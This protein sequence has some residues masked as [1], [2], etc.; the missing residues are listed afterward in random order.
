MSAHGGFTYL[1]I[2][3]SKD[4]AFMQQHNAKLL[5]DYIAL[6][7]AG[8][9]INATYG[10]Y[11]KL[12]WKDNQTLDNDFPPTS[13]GV[14]VPNYFARF[15][16]R[17]DPLWIDRSPAMEGQVGRV[18]KPTFNNTNIWLVQFKPEQLAQ[19]KICSYQS[20]KYPWI[21]AVYKYKHTAMQPNRPDVAHVTIP[22]F[23]GSGRYLVH[24]LWS[25]YRDVIDVDYSDSTTPVAEI[26]GYPPTTARWR[27]IDHCLFDNP[28]AVYDLSE[29]VTDATHCLRRC[30][31]RSS[32]WGVNVVP[33]KAPET[34]YKFKQPADTIWLFPD[35]YGTDIY[36]PWNLTVFNATKSR[37]LANATSDKFICYTVMPADF[38][39]TTD[40]YTVS[41]DPDD[42]IFY[43]TCYYRYRGYSFPGYVDNT[44]L[45]PGL[46]PWRFNDKCV[47]CANQAVN[48]YSNIV[49]QWSVSEKCI[50][51]DKE[52]VTV[53]QPTLPTLNLIES[54]VKCDGYGS[55]S[56]AN[57]HNCTGPTNTTDCY[58]QLYPLGRS[59]STN[60][61]LDE[62]RAMVANNPN[63][64]NY[65]SWTFNATSTRCYC[66][67][68]KECCKTCSR[69]IDL[70]MATYELVTV[71]DPNCDT[72][73]LSADGK[74]CC[75]ASCGVGGC[76]NTTSTSVNNVGFCHA[77][78]IT[79]SCTQYGP[80]CLIVQ[81]KK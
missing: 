51:C 19:D 52:P 61:T 39:D 54:G 55:W 6:A 70:A 7:P 68:T 29:V 21:E 22:G 2:V 80:P 40:E 72:G 14:S 27:R 9:T 18:Q 16:D 59:T 78:V 79:R 67:L 44:A 8:A 12:H 36:V 17:T 76:L 11:M 31:G 46:G 47:D 60:V 23:G 71:P 77:N 26:Y 75:S 33:L 56:R 34:A 43:S 37:L 3:H 13:T 30:E 45:S 42:P 73:V 28:R 24:Y 81:K 35:I 58:T 65:F 50:N 48:V 20:T 49:P 1:V 38:T 53:P 66:Y 69:R 32:C 74:S 25:G 5:D 15:I 57:H 41:K 4:K 62:C 64:S 63:C 10:E